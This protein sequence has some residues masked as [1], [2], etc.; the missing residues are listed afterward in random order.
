ML[1]KRQYYGNFNNHGQS[2][3]N[4]FYNR[5]YNNNYN[6]WHQQRPN[7]GYNRGRYF[8]RYDARPA[9]QSSPSNFPTSHASNF[10][11]LPYNNELLDQNSFQIAKTWLLY[12][13]LG[14]QYTNLTTLETIPSFDRLLFIYPLT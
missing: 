9:S 1:F 11:P 13:R 8:R 14:N 6:Y 10:P 4:R 5:N 7:T 2:T 12:V 3:N